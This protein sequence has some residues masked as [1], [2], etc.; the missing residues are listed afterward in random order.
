[1]AD[2]HTKY[3]APGFVPEGGELRKRST[4]HLEKIDFVQF[5]L[6]SNYGARLF[7]SI[8]LLLLLA[9]C[10][11]FV[12]AL[13]LLVGFR[14]H[15]FAFAD[16]WTAWRIFVLLAGTIAMVA[17]LFRMLLKSFCGTQDTDTK[18][19]RGKSNASV[20]TKKSG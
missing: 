2:S 19:G 18:Q 9:I 3:D 6:M 8:A 12:L 15:E 7:H 20:A 11:V 13:T 10:V 4:E 17:G 1:M 5:G 14:P 16:Q